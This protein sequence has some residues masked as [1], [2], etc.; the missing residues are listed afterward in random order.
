VLGVKDHFVA[1]KRT[2]RRGLVAARIHGDSMIGDYIHHGDTGIFQQWDFEYINSGRVAL[3]EKVGEEEGTGAWAVKRIVIW[4]GRS[5]TP[6]DVSHNIDWDDPIIE[7]TSSNP[8]IKASPLDP[9]G[10]YRVRGQLL[11]VVRP[12]SVEL[13]DSADLMS[14]ME[15]S[16]EP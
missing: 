12:E 10:Q 2:F 11:R 6:S 15:Q 8:S 4:H 14:A 9:T 13:I 3:I 16:N 1:G 5:R 7:V